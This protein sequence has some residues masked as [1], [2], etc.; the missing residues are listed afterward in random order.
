MV[1]KK[2]EDRELDYL[3]GSWAEKVEINLTK[4]FRKFRQSLV[5]SLL[6]KALGIFQRPLPQV[7][8]NLD[9]RFVDIMAPGVNSSFRKNCL[10]KHLVGLIET[11]I[12]QDEILNYF[13]RIDILFYDFQ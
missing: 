6:N 3:P 2:V 11:E 4:L 8:R 12:K 7:I 5:D 9:M 1:G 13:F 10:L